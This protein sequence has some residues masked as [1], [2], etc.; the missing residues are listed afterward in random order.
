MLSQYDRRQL[1][2]ISSRQHIEDPE[3][4]CSLRDGKPRPQPSNHSWP[5]MVLGALAGL[6]VVVGIVLMSVGFMILG[7]M[8]FSGITFWY[9]RVV[10][11]SPK[12][13]VF[14][15]LFHR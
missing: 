3:F 1:E 9:R 6:V 14:R 11:R 2:L 13:G 12:A 10:R 4:A 5:F 7:A 15:K 8:A